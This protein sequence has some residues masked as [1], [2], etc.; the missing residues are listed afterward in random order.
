MK[1]E[2]GMMDCRISLEEATTVRLGSGEVSKSWS[3][4]TGLWSHRLPKGSREV[5]N[6]DQKQYVEDV[7]FF[8]HYRT[9]ITPGGHRIKEGSKIFDIKSIEEVIQ[10]GNYNL[11]SFLKLV[12]EHVQ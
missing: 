4:L 7:E 11:R 1:V 5:Y 9:G 10:E 2:T 6:G 8:I 3:L 12:C